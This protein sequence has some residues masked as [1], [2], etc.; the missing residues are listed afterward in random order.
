LP[1]RDLIFMI[2]CRLCDMAII[3]C[4]R[5][6]SIASMAAHTAQTAMTDFMNR[7]RDYL[8]VSYRHPFAQ[9]PRAG[10]PPAGAAVL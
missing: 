5:I 7:M 1:R 9:S 3:F 6:V 10:E 2:P 4:R 8:P